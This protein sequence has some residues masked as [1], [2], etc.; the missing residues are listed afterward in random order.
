M[1]W[2]KALLALVALFLVFI[3]GILFAS[4]N[5][6]PVALDLVVWQLPEASV[7]IWIAAGFV[8]GGLLGLLMGLVMI[9][10]LKT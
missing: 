9:V 3:W 4:E 2:I 8:V 5:V 10:R 7:S 1:K 6:Q